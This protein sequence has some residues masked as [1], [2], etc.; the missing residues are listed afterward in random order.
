MWKYVCVV[1]V[2]A[3]CVVCAVWVLSVCCVFIKTVHSN[4]LFPYMLKLNFGN[5]CVKILQPQQINNCPGQFH[6]SN[7]RDNNFCL[8]VLP[9]TSEWNVRSMDTSFASNPNFTSVAIT[10]AK[11]LHVIHWRT[12]AHDRSERFHTWYFPL[13]LECSSRDYIN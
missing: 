6:M 11:C 12:S 8:N 10:R 1:A 2:C 7:S 3:M 4:I 5:C 9:T 13:A